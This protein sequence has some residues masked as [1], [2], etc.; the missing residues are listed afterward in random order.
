M[1]KIGIIGIILSLFLL[2]CGREIEKNENI[3]SQKQDEISQNRF[4]YLE[5]CEE[6][7][8]LKLDILEKSYKQGEINGEDYRN[9]KQELEQKE[10]EYQL[11]KDVLGYGEKLYEPVAIQDSDKKAMKR[12]LLELKEEE[13]DLEKEMEKTKKDY[14]EKIISQEDF[15]LVRSKQLEEEERLQQEEDWLENKLKQ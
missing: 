2:E 5:A 15:I 6:I 7:V 4:F 14:M 12:R 1:K 13:K 8:D 3:S 10:E 11:E 9:Q